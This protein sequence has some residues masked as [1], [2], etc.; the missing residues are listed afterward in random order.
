M[1]AANDTT[2]APKKRRGRPPKVNGA[3]TTTDAP[4]K[5]VEVEAVQAGKP[6]GFAACLAK[7]LHGLEEANKLRTGVSVGKPRKDTFFRVHPEYH[8]TLTVVM[9]STGMDTVTHA[10]TPAVQE[11]MQDAKA[12]SE[13]MKTYDYTLVITRDGDVKLWPL[14]VSASGDM[15][16]SWNESARAVAGHAVNGWVRYCSNRGEG[17]YEVIEP[18]SVLPDPEWPVEPWDKLLELAF[19]DTMIDSVEH[20]YLLKLQG[21]E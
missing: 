12:V 11:A 3:D 2:T 17:R 7:P 9:E 21:I 5:P 13:V 20:P 6:I 1:T 15:P 10:M 18:G 4:E 19:K 16:N 14:V 8:Q